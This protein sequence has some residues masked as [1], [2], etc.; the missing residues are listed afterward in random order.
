[1]TLKQLQSLIIH[2]SLLLVHVVGEAAKLGRQSAS[3]MTSLVGIN[4]LLHVAPKSCIWPCALGFTHDDKL[5]G[6]AANFR[7]RR[8]R[9]LH[10]LVLVDRPCVLFGEG[11]GVLNGL[12]GRIHSGIAHEVQVRGGT[13]RDHVFKGCGSAG[14]AG[15]AR[16][17][18]VVGHM[19]EGVL[20][21]AFRRSC[22]IRP[23]ERGTVILEVCP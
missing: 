2:P 12:R 3:R 15:A 11:L 1:M 18:L 5:V 8:L 22:R 14:G 17:V 21:A 9:G 20:D 23:Q 7:S 16:A 4:F 10:A 13:M 19:E 6:G